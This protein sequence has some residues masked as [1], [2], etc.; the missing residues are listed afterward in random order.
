[1]GKVKYKQ[2]NIHYQRDRVKREQKDKHKEAITK[3]LEQ[4]RGSGSGGSMTGGYLPVSQLTSE[5]D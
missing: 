2:T 5:D 3:A 1:M 4:S